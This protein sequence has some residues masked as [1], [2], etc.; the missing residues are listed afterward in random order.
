MMMMKRE[1]VTKKYNNSSYRLPQYSYNK[2]GNRKI[3]KNTNVEVSKK[4]ELVVIFVLIG[5]H[6][7]KEVVLLAFAGW[8]K[9]WKSSLNKHTR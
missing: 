1:D 7:R 5:Q 9:M 8:S 3:T 4:F 6:G 2:I